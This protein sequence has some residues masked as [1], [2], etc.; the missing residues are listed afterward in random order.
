MAAAQFILY[1]EVGLAAAAGLFAIY[2][3]MNSGTVRRALGKATHRS[4]TP[5]YRRVSHSRR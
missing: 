3:W 5:V 1:A 2:K 4:R